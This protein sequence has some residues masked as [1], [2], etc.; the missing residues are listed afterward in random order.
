VGSR[1]AFP[2]D[3]AVLT[4]SLECL[5]KPGSRFGQQPKGRRIKKTEGSYRRRTKAIQQS[6]PRVTQLCAEARRFSDDFTAAVATVPNSR[7]SSKEE[8][9]GHA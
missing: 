9:R 7:S 6:W 1:G 8:E 5:E 3:Q 2:G 4:G